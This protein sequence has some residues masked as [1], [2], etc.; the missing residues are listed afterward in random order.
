MFAQTYKI[1]DFG[2]SRIKEVA[3]GGE[4]N[5]AMTQVGTPNWTA[6]EVWQRRLSKA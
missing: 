2:I 5:V 3:K 6:P 4:Q 1:A